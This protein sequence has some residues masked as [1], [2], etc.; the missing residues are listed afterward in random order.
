MLHRKADQTEM[1]DRQRSD[2]LANDDEHDEV[3]RPQ[4]RGEQDQ[5]E[6]INCTKQAA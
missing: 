4:F 2:Q 3:S 5:R 1:I 6:H